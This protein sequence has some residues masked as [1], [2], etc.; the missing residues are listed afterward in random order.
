MT[1]ETD[2][3][4]G[5]DT[6]NTEN[7]MALAAFLEELP[8]HSDRHFDMNCWLVEDHHGDTEFGTD[9]CDTA[10][11]IAGWAYV[12]AKEA[13]MPEANFPNGALPSEIRF[14]ATMFLGLGWSQSRAL[15]LPDVVDL[16]KVS[17]EDAIKVLRH[18]ADTGEVDWEGAG[19]E[20]EYL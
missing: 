7:V 11:C 15:F 3:E 4:I 6:V 19:V 9:G 8:E 10:G 13:G 2:T 1:T 16:S 18:L 14:T 5:F 20:L 17:V 12:L